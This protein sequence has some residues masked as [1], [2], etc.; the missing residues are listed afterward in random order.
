ML[1]GV[2]FELTP[3]DC[4]G[5]VG[6]AARANPRSRADLGGVAAE[7][8]QGAIDGADVAQWPRAE[9]GPHVGYLPQ[10]VEL[11]PGTVAENIAR[12]ED[13]AAD[14]VVAAAQWAQVHDMIL[15]FPQGYDTPIMAGGLMLS[16]ASGNASRSRARCI[17]RRS[18]S[19][20]T[21]RTRTSTETAISRSVRRSSKRKRAAA[22]LIVIAHR[23]AVLREADKVLVLRD[24]LVQD[25]GARDEV[26]ARVAQARARRR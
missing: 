19:C 25:Y 23:M 2:S 3:G 13:P 9:L 10:E 18:C 5:I 22:T 17:A 7:Q 14:D 15:R 4:L 12:M 24:G 11:F 16:P 1:K 6:P 20:W 21:S 8:R 26:L